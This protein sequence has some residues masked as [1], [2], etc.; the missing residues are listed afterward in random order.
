MLVSRSADGRR[1]QDTTD[2]NESV[3]ISLLAHLENEKERLDEK[4]KLS[5]VSHVASFHLTHAIIERETA[6]NRHFSFA[7]S[8]LGNKF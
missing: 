6:G 8:A 1:S 5:F 7:R 2:I 3:K 4:Q